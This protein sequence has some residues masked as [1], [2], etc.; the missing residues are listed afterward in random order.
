MRIA[1]DIHVT[2]NEDLSTAIILIE[3][4]I[5]QVMRTNGSIKELRSVFCL[6]SIKQLYQFR[7]YFYPEVSLR[8]AVT[9]QKW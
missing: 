3:R 1:L 9:H 6:T 4:K 7:F 8:K 5:K 2:L